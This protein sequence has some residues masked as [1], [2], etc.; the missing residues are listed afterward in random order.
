MLGKTNQ[1]M[2]TLLFIAGIL[3]MVAC[4][5]MEET[6]PIL[7]LDS[8]LMDLPTTLKSMENGDLDESSANARKN[9]ATKPDSYAT[10]NAALGST[11]LARVFAQNDLTVFAPTDRAFAELGLFPGNIRQVPNLREILLYHVVAGFVYSTD[12][13]EGYVPTVNG[14]AVQI[15]LSNGAMVNDANIVMVD[16]KAR[17]GVIHGIDKVLFPPT[18][19]LVEL[20]L[21]NENLSILVA[22]VVAADLVDAL[23][24]GNNLTVFAPTNDAFI[25][26]LADFEVNSLDELIDK[27]GIDLL[28]SVLLYHVVEGRVFSSD[29]MNGNVESL[30]GETFRVDVSGPSLIDKGGN[31]SNI[32]ATDIQATNGTVHVI[33]RV[34][35]PL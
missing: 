24:T 22:A 21:G 13:T 31:V 10:F 20:A 17:N 35:L 5:G 6:E 4:N 7:E 15:S 30:M 34:I 18:Q 27:I 29:L 2:R 12:L 23:A 1:M 26:L 33:D 8:E 9:N 14:A 11:G 3:L 16:K 25:A 32:I 28:R 19:N